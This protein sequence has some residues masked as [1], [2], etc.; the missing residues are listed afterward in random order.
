MGGTKKGGKKLR[1]DLLSRDPD[2]YKKIRAKR[3][4]YPKHDGLFDSEK[5]K[6]AGKKGGEISSR[7]KARQLPEVVK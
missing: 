5:A 7:P 3:K 4:S 6:E 1:D 2:Y